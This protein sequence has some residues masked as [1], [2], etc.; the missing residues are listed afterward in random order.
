MWDWDSLQSVSAWHTWLKFAAVV[1]TVLLALF[2]IVLQLLTGPRLE[3]LKRAPR[4]LSERQKT[5]LTEALS[6]YS[7]TKIKVQCSASDIESTQYAQGFAKIF[8]TAG[9]RVEF[10]PIPFGNQR[11]WIPLGISMEVRYHEEEPEGAMPLIEALRKIGIEA[12][13][14]WRDHYADPGL[15]SIEFRVGQK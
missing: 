8:R 6:E 2:A 11:N 10:A 13:V 7:T 4:T 5:A 14:E 3:E 1:C 9:W 15:E 12:D